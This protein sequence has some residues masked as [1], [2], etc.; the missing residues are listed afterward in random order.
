MI[1][2]N[3]WLKKSD[4]D[5]GNLEYIT[6]SNPKIDKTEKFAWGNRYVYEIYF[7]DTKKSFPYY[8]INPIETLYF[9]SDFVKIHC[10]GLINRGYII[11]E[12]ENGEVWKLEKKD[13]WVNLEEKIDEIK[14]NKKISQ[15]DKDK[16]LGILKGTFGKLPHMK[17]RLNQAIDKV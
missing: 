13:P 15:E 6:I 12:A 5:Q 3:F 1:K 4:A 8:G 17:D 14:N 16:I 11:S 9:A 2:I 7:S 10:Q